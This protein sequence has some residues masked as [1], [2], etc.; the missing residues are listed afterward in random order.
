MAKNYDN[1]ERLVRAGSNSIS[2]T[3]S[4][5]DL[6]FSSSSQFDDCQSLVRRQRRELPIDYSDLTLDHLEWKTMLPPD[7]KEVVWKSA[8]FLDKRTG[9]NCFLL[10]S[11]KLTMSSEDDYKHCWERKSH[12]KSRFSEVA[13]LTDSDNYY[14]LGCI[15]TQM[16]SP[17][18][19]LCAAYLVFRLAEKDDTV[20]TANS[21]IRIFYCESHFDSKKQDR[22][23]H[24]QLGNGRADGWMEIEPGDFYV[25]LGV[26]AD[27]EV[28]LLDKSGYREEQLLETSV[29]REEQ[30][31]ETGYRRSGRV[32]SFDL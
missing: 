2:S 27:V 3:S 6:S 9:K 1:W 21:I 11:T 31:L 17:P 7:K 15:K 13:E 25:D 10:G 23:V 12:L 30:L 24:F 26:N 4:S 19:T 28:E 8:F 14:V 5:F 16:L 22:L 32:L 29:Y 18:D 20:L